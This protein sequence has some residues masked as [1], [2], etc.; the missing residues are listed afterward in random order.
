ML[1][2]HSAQS[3]DL[4]PSVIKSHSILR[5][6]MGA[7]CISTLMVA[8]ISIGAIAQTLSPSQSPSSTDPNTVPTE[9]AGSADLVTEPAS[10]SLIQLV[11]LRVPTLPMADAEARVNQKTPE[12]VIERPERYGEPGPAQPD[13]VEFLLE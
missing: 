12:R 5:L 4:S 2:L 10:T 7:A 8:L 1:T 9:N 11:E 3:T 13:H 6:V